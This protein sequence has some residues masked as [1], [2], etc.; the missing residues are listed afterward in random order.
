MKIAGSTYYCSKAGSNHSTADLMGVH[1]ASESVLNCT[2]LELAY[3]V[4][5]MA[6][7]LNLGNCGDVCPWNIEERTF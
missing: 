4:R 1:E 7:G 2:D 5:I 3:S 6:C